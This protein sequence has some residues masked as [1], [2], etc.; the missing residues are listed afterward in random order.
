MASASAGVSAPSRGARGAMT[1]RLKMSAFAARWPARV[2]L[3][4][5]VHQRGER[6][7]AETARAGR[8]CASFSS[9]VCGRP[10][11]CAAEKTG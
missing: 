6:V 5:R 2:E 4:Q 11:R 1:R 9:P 3:L 8:I 7:V 10:G